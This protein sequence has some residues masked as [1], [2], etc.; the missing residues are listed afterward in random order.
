MAFVHN[1]AR[2]HRRIPYNRKPG[3]GTE[4]SKAQADGEYVIP[5]GQTVEIPDK[6]LA[7]F[8]LRPGVAAWFAVG[9]LIEVKEPMPVVEPPKMMAAV[10][11]PVADVPVAVDE[12]EVK[13]GPFGRIKK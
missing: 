13:R 12:P 3:E 7:K 2:S 9:D 5:G 11:E 8:K 6:L 4:W 1:K 10:P